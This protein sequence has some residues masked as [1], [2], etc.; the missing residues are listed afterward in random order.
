MILAKQLTVSIGSN[1]LFK[2]VTFSLERG[3]I[4][5]LVAPNGYGKTTLMKLLAGVLGRSYSGTVEVD[6]VRV[7]PQTPPRSKIM[8]VSGDG[9]LLYDDVT[10]R[11]HLRLVSDVWRRFDIIDMA[12]R[13]GISECLGRPV[14]YLSLGQKQRLVLGMAQGS[15]VDY[16]LLDEPFN[17]LDP[18]GIHAAMKTLGAYARGGHGLLVSSHILAELAELC[19]SVLF[20]TKIGVVEID[21]P[22]TTGLVERFRSLYRPT[23]SG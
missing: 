7:D 11:G 19:S 21:S 3:E 22:T 13:Y 6:G 2:R 16:L 17:G 12:S 4:K 8:H 18:T 5:G 23:G 14:R 10:A 20:L 9:S 1:V 15:G